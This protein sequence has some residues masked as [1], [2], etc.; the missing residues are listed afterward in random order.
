MNKYES[1]KISDDLKRDIILHLVEPNYK[2]DISSSLKLKKTFKNLGLTFETLSKFFVGVSSI[3]SFASGIYKYQVLSFI[4][5]TSSVVSLVLLQYSS[6]SYRESKKITTEINNTLK[7]LNIDTIP[8]DKSTLDDVSNPDT[9]DPISP[10]P[11]HTP[12]SSL[13]R[14]STLK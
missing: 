2:S 13:P 7:K 12:P 11:P 3:T 1:F 10:P 4:A 5:G 8:I 14:I 9:N 6:F